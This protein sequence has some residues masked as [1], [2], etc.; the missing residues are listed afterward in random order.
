MGETLFP[1]HFPHK[2]QPAIRRRTVLSDME[3][4]QALKRL[5]WPIIMTALSACGPG[6]AATQP[7]ILAAIPCRD[8]GSAAKAIRIAEEWIADRKSRY[9][10]VVKRA[11]WQNDL[12][13]IEF[14]AWSGE[15]QGYAIA[16]S[17]PDGTVVRCK[18]FANCVVVPTPDKPACPASRKRIATRGQAVDIASR[19]LAGQGIRTDDGAQPA[20][21]GGPGWWV[22]VELEPPMPG[23]HYILLISADGKVTGTIPGE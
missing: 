22:S 17:M 9:K 8:Y 20:V 12:W 4:S 10:E 11:S 23:G 6:A 16:T 18:A 3:Y 13:S 14:T 1:P 5:V 7:V 15:K 21:Y 19:F 2:L